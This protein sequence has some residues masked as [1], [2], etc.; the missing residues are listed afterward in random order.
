MLPEIAL[1]LGRQN[2]VS[3][4][5]S[6][7]GR[8]STFV[9]K[10]FHDFLECYHQVGAVVTQAADL[11]F[12][13][14]SYLTRVAAEGTLYVEFMLSPDHSID[15]GIAYHDQIDAVA[16]GIDQARHRTGIEA[17]L[18]VTSVRHRGPE[19]AEAL[20][21]VVA[22][23]PHPKVVG[24]GLTGNEY[25]H[26][27]RDFSRAFH[28]AK[29][30]GLGLTAHAGEWREGQTVRDAIELLKLDRVGHG[31]RVVESVELLKFAAE[32][33]VGFEICLSSNVA[34]GAVGEFSNHPIKQ[35]LAAGCRV[36]LATDDP[37][38]FKTSPRLEIECAVNQ[39]GLDAEDVA[40]TV[41]NGI[42]L[43]FCDAELK[44]SLRQRVALNHSDA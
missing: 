30:A 12:L 18:I 21:R 7:L 19:G 23:N 13:A 2:S 44:S 25:A 34:L 38:F 4:P 29:E 8:D 11:A 36:T 32:R 3:V 24:F 15:N 39:V 40:A 20:A 31:I 35:M 16:S 1:E 43:A 6:R 14:E 42:E 28:I 41:R 26:E 22:A 37:G 10:G 5:S 33:E 9:F 27:V 17:R